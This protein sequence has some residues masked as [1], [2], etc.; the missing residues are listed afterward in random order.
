MGHEG[1]E[2]GAIHGNGPD[3]E[4][5]LPARMEELEETLARAREE[6]DHYVERAAEFI[7]ER[8]VASVAGAVALGWLIGR[9]ASRR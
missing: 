4:S 5:A 3:E 6:L 9:I 2:N 1:R 7:R 8:P